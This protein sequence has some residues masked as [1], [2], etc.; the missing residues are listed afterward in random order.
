MVGRLPKSGEYTIKT[1]HEGDIRVVCERDE[2]H[3]GWTVES[4]YSK[5]I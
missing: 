5:T 3:K 2:D 4:N 1:Q